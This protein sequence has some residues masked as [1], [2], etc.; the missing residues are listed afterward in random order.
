MGNALVSIN[1]VGPGLSATR[2]LSRN[3]VIGILA[4]IGGNTPGYRPC[5]DP[6]NDYRASRVLH[7]LAP[8]LIAS[9]WP[10]LYSASSDPW[11]RDSTTA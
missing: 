5:R 4:S 2:I 9:L 6:N 8:A 10:V 1:G 11:M 3:G 7:P